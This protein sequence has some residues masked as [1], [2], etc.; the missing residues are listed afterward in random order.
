M[1]I[2]WSTRPS[3]SIATQREVKSDSAPPN[4]SGT[5]RPNSPSSP[6][7]G[8]RSTGKWCVAVPG[9]DVRG[10][11]RLGEVAHQ[12]AE[13]LVVLAELEHRSGPS[14]DA[15][16]HPALLDVDVNVK[17]DGRRDNPVQAPPRCHHRPR[18]A[19]AAGD[20]WTIAE[21]AERV[22]RHPPHRAPLRG[23][24]P[25]LP[26]AP[27]H[28]RGSTTA[29]TGRGS[30]SSC[31]A[32]GSGFPL[33]EIRTIIDMYDEQPGEAGQLDLP[34]RPDRRPA[35][36]ARTPPAGHRGLPHRARRP[37]APLRGRPARAALSARR[38]RPAAPA[39]RCAAAHAGPTQPRTRAVRLPT[40]PLRG[41][42]RRSRR[43]RRTARGR[44]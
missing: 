18:R 11:L 3:S 23:P 31:A 43:G 16:D 42:W 44:R 24:R 12:R 21:V 36:R 40:R 6:I 39:S 32:S 10:D 4:S 20:T 17:H 38:R 35:R 8:T 30:T 27:R 19:G 22:R 7:L 33:E 34:A 1:P 28:A 29:G 9:G 26:R 5:T 37:R 14:S 25:D 13:L 15:E 2:D 41:R